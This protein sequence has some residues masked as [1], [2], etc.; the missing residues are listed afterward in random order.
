ML[1]QLAVFKLAQQELA[2]Q[3]LPQLPQQQ[4]SPLGLG[5][6]FQH[7]QEGHQTSFA[8]AGS[9]L[10]RNYGPPPKASGGFMTGQQAVLGGMQAVGGDL[11]AIAGMF[12]MPFITSFASKMGIDLNKPFQYGYGGNSELFRE[13][14]EINAAVNG[15]RLSNN[16]ATLKKISAALIDVVRK[17]MGE[18]PNTDKVAEFIEGLNPANLGM[19]IQSATMVFPELQTILYTVDPGFISDFSPLVKSTYIDGD[20][21]FNVDV[22][23]NKVN[24][25]NKVYSSGAFEDIPAQI[26][27]HAVH[28]SKEELGKGATIKDAVNYAKA[29]NSLV[30]NQ[31]APDF[32]SAMGIVSAIDSSGA[33]AKNPNK[34][35]AYSN[36]LNDMVRKGGLDPRFIGQAAQVAKENGISIGVALNAVTMGSRARKSVG[37]ASGSVQAD[38]ATNAITGLANTTEMKLLAA[39]YQGDARARKVIDKA[40]DTGDR[41]TLNSIMRS[42]QRN[43]R[44]MV[45]AQRVDASGLATEIAYRNPAV[46]DSFVAGQLDQVVGRNQELASLVRNK[47][48]LARRIKSQDYTGLSSST[49]QALRSYGG[50]LGAVALSLPDRKDMRRLSP[51]SKPLDVM[52]TRLGLSYPTGVQD[53]KS[54]PQGAANVRNRSPQE[55]EVVPAGSVPDSGTRL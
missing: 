10:S 8:G 23:N 21:K 32:G 52:P 38:I 15:H 45:E 26:A 46:M 11:G 42:L 7:I 1:G 55:R 3:E 16:S 43:P 13:T 9:P 33:T 30:K 2:Q 29:A 22:F 50:R 36:Y 12:G 17:S 48:E 27:M 44:A 28:H 6:L 37:G 20:G 34:V 24:E 40:I 25:F 35:I 47:S 39:A 14:Q 53:D 41:N 31:L 49:R 4:S 51:P 5:N 18:G 19:F 54:N